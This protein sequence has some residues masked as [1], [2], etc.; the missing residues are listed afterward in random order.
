MKTKLPIKII[1]DGTDSGTKVIDQNTGL[2][3]PHI[4]SVSWEISCGSIGVATIRVLSE[5]DILSLETQAEHAI[6]KRN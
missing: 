1:S 6:T 2:E 4:L 5:C 3:L